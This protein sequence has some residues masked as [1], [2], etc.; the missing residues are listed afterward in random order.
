[1]VGWLYEPQK[2]LG[3]IFTNQL[4]KTLK[5]AEVRIEIDDFTAVHFKVMDQAMLHLL[6]HVDAVP[7]G[8]PG[9]R[10]GNH[11]WLG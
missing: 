4:A 10:I 1:M 9:N 8:L 6:R 5:G 7:V 2:N 3:L 11:V